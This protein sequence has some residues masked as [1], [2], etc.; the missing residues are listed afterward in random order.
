[1]NS[2][3]QKL[4]PFFLIISLLILPMTLIAK[5]RSGTDLVIQK[6]DGQQAKGEL[7]AVKK[8]SLLLKDSQTGA[9]VNVDIADIETI[10]IVKNSKFLLGAGLGLLIGGG[11]GAIIGSAAEPQ[12]T[13]SPGA[14]KYWYGVF[15]GAL[16]LLLGA[17]WGL[18]A[19]KDK[20]IQIEGLPSDTIEFY[21]EDLR[22]KARVPDFQ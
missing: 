4:I 16:G 19:G 17:I 13:D 22:K 12:E 8:N 11:G 9:D 14:Y 15:F 2:K 6:K 18:S 10:T 5:E 7:I 20:I 21:L 1:M 3:G